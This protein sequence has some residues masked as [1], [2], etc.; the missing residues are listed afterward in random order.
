MNKDLHKE[1][2]DLLDEIETTYSKVSSRGAPAYHVD[3]IVIASIKRAKCTAL[4]IRSL[5]ELDNL[6]CSKVLLRTLLDTSMRFAALFLTDNFGLAAIKILEDDTRI[7]DLKSKGNKKL[8]DFY[9]VEELSKVFPHLKVMYE[10]LNA[11]V[12]FSKAHVESAFQDVSDI[13]SHDMS[14]IEKIESYE[15]QWVLANIAYCLYFFLYYI[16]AFVSIKNL[17]I[18][19]ETGKKIDIS[20]SKKNIMGRA[21]GLHSYFITPGRSNVSVMVC[22]GE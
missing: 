7:R 17:W 11:Y 1:I 10:E 21:G 20:S 2:S 13:N 18:E 3:M 14:S 8:T 19:K 6:M 22:A 12:H 4:G 16:D 5:L 9:I 15:R